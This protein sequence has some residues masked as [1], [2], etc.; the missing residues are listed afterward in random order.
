MKQIE[1]DIPSALFNLFKDNPK[2]IKK[3]LKS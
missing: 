2:K 1:V 3:M